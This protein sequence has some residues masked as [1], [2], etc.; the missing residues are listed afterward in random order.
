MSCH[1]G[2]YIS[3]DKILNHK[4]KNLAVI[5]F[6]FFFF[7]PGMLMHTCISSTKE[8]EVGGSRISGQAGFYIARPCHGGKKKPKLKWL[9]F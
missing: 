7:K 6:F 8:A 1:L 3:C 2:T 5:H 4:T 9:Y